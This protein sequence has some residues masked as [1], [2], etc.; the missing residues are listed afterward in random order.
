LQ[1][2]PDADSVSLDLAGAG[3][4]SLV[5]A[6]PA[7]ARAKMDLLF[8]I[9][10]DGLMTVEYMEELYDAGTVRRLA[11]AYLALLAAAA[12]APYTPAADVDLATPEDAKLLASFVPGTMHPEYL[13]APLTVHGF[14]EV[15][16]AHPDRVALEFE[17]Q[18]MTYSELNARAN[19]LAHQLV[20][21]GVCHDVVLGIMLER[22]FELIIAILATLK[23]GGGY[24]PLD[25][26]YPDDRLSIYTEDA[27]VAL[28][29][30]SSDLSPRAKAL[31]AAGGREST[32][33]LLVEA[34][35]AGADP[36]NLP[37]SR[38]QP[39]G[40][41]Y[42]IFTSGSTGRPK[43]A[44]LLHGGLRDLTLWL[45]DYFQCGPE[46]V[47]LLTNTISF[48][49]HVLQVFPP[50]V[51]GAK[52][53]IA[54]PRGHLDPDYMADLICSSA[55]TG[56]IFTVPTLMREW[57]ACLGD[58]RPEAMRM[59]GIGGENVSLAD[60]A[61]MQKTFPNIR[62]PVNS[63]GPT[64]V[65]A[66]T[67]NHT[68]E[69]GAN[70]HVLGRPDYNVHAYVVD[71]KLR[72]VPVGVPGELLLSGP[73]LGR[74]Y[75]G[76]PDIT[77]EKFIQNP[78]YRQYIDTVPPALQPHFRLAYRTGDLVRWRPDGYIDFLGRID[79]QVKVNGVRIELGEVEI[80]MGSFAGKANKPRTHMHS[81]CCPQWARL[82]CFLQGVM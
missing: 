72:P 12:A 33:T 59:W 71:A 42:A 61:L 9:G 19:R 75:I 80:T 4:V 28:M 6:P 58:R 47:V 35:A 7:P 14:E 2:L 64:E 53:V 68:F 11:G 50:L 43:G 41:C 30:T 63:Y 37:R 49:A 3:R 56:L 82:P 55:A 40:A 34:D 38:A 77:A 31:L 1:Y 60:V 51:V 5:T 69:P 18:P 76:R 45:V 21:R 52:L 27:A 8:N 20:E 26:A 32:P 15:A 25:P 46:D 57:V 67:V 70:V 29:L 73:R 22:S 65:T 13:S 78:C 74:G 36:G 23:A 44:Q 24:L 66:L 48:D 54:S 16:A 10:G 39:D 62:G 17:G 79:R 81:A